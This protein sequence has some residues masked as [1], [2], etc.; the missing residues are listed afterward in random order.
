MFG[1]VRETHHLQMVDS[2]HQQRGR[3]VALD[4][5]T[6]IACLAS[7]VFGFDSCVWSVVLGPCPLV[8]R[9]GVAPGLLRLSIA[10][11]AYNSHFLRFRCRFACDRALL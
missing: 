1:K 6:L 5:E 4:L 3:L 10:V 9:P 2:R 7:S 11:V 8:D